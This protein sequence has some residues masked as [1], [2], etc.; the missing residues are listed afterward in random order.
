MKE[1]LR[2]KRLLVQGAGRGNLG[3]VK[4]AKRNGVYVVM[5]GLGGDYPCNPYADKFC[6][7]DIS[8]PDAILK[9]AKAERVDGVA[10]CC[11]DTGLIPIGCCNDHLGLV[12][13]SE[14]AALACSDK[15][16][17]KQKLLS[18]GVRTP[19]SILVRTEE[20]LSVALT[21]LTFPLVIK[22]VD[23]QGSRGISVVSSMEEAVTAF[24]ESISLSRKDYCL[25][26]EFIVGREFGAQAF[27][28]RGNVLFVLPH[29]DDTIM[30]GA[31]V[32]VGHYI[33]YVMSSEMT[34]DVKTQVVNAISSLEL[35]NC[36]VNVDLIERDGKVYVLELSGRVGANCLPEL[37]GNYFSFDYYE[38]ILATALGFSPLSYFKG[39]VQPC[40]SMSCMLR[41]EVSGKVVSIE[42][43][44]DELADIRLFIH[45]GSMVREFS[46]CNDAIGEVIVKD[47]SLEACESHLSSLCCKILKGIKYE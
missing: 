24:R 41:S 23:L 19:N 13:L 30:C 17:M 39:S 33:P 28:Y 44:K 34:E 40:F 5:T 14:Q 6:Y 42:S 46:N 31:P 25:V 18:A 32:P 21:R 45:L 15:S 20:D 12:G 8:N 16:I 1:E 3:L 22:A 47:T 35:D 43:V 37:V 9:I 10:I 27:V 7:G 26:E 2:G 36:A 29:G 11:S 4:A 38:V